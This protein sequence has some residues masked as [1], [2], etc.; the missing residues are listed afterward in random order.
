[1]FRIMSSINLHM[2]NADISNVKKKSFLLDGVR[3]A[4][5]DW[6]VYMAMRSYIGEGTTFA[7]NQVHQG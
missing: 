3:S 7:W 4:D 1:M 2:F 5:S 6:G